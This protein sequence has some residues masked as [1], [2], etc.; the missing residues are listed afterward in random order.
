MLTGSSRSS[1]G[2]FRSQLAPDMAGYATSRSL[3]DALNGRLVS[4]DGGHRRKQ[5]DDDPQ[6]GVVEIKA[7]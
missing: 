1:G 4:A 3:G 6:P 7:H 2:K 5:L